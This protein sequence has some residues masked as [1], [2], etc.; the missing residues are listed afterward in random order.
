MVINMMFGNVHVLFEDEMFTGGEL[1]EIIKNS[2]EILK[3][4]M[5]AERSEHK[6]YY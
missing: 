2:V 5:E 1:T 3:R 4:I 6:V